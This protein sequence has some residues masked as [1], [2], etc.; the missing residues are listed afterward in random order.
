MFIQPVGKWWK[1]AKHSIAWRLLTVAK[2]GDRHDRL[3]A[4]QQLACIDH[5]KDWDYQHLAQICDAR[6]A[7]SLARHQCDARWFLPAPRRGSVR[8]PKSLIAEIRDKI[9][10]LKPSPCIDHF[11]VGAF[12][13]F[14][15]LKGYIDD[16]GVQPF[17]R[18]QISKQEFDCLRQC[19]E[20]MFHLTRNVDAART[21]IAAGFLQTLIEVQKLFFYNNEMRFM[22]SKVMSNLSMCK[23][24]TEDFFVTGWVGILAGW[25]R[26]PDLRVQVTAAKALANMDVEDVTGFV[27][28]PSVYPLYPTTRSKLQHDVDMVFVHGL[29]GECET[30]EV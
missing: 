16:R 29:L 15:I 18:C 27:Y 3:K 10:L 5:L 30:N 25:S 17:G 22:L 19:L 4:V 11:Y 7:V 24:S 28:Q 2:T 8:Q 13:K 21:L 12:N 23:E 14:A 1:A 20:V 6:T 26:N 9:N